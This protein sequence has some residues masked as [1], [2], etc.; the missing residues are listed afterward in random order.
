MIGMD[1]EKY[2]GKSGQ[3]ISGLDTTGSDLYFSGTGNSNTNTDAQIIA[4]FFA[5][6]DNVL[7]IENGQMVAH[8]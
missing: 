2:S 4:S 6:F 8:Y 3:I 1:F 5:H 7:V